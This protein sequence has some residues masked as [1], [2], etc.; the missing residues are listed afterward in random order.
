MARIKH[1]CGAEPNREGE[2]PEIYI[3]GASPVRRIE[4]REQN[5][6]TYGIMWFDVFSDDALIASMNASHVASVVYFPDDPTA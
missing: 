2:Y 3:V 6:G 1:I 4:A 5:L